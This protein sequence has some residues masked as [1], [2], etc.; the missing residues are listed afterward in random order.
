MSEEATTPDHAELTQRSFEL[1]VERNFDAVMTFY[2]SDVVWDG[3][4]RGI[5]TFAGVAATRT[6]FEDWFGNYDLFEIEMEEVR[7]FGNGVVLA[8]N[9]QQA[10]PTGSSGLVRTREAYLFVWR[11]N[12]IKRVTMYEDVDEA[13]AAAERL[14]AERG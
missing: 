4:D 12:L 10:R 1:A 8:V 14:A 6:L 11:Q 7:D 9:E 2:A 5:G 13:R 3:S